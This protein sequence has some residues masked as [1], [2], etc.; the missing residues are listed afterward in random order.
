MGYINLK[1]IEQKEIVKGYQARF[2]H[3]GNMTT[4]YWEVEA[5]AVLPTHSHL[6][7]Q[8][9]NVTRGRF[10][11]TL[12]G[13]TRILEPGDVVIIPPDVPHC[14]KAVTDCEIIDTFHPVREDY[15]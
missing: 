2:V 11:F 4:A 7:E 1:D 8:V 9:S 12:D 10:E 3:S 13:E 5:G 15:R 6:H 14:G